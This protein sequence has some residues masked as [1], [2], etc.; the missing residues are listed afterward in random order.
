[1]GHRYDTNCSF[2]SKHFWNNSLT[3]VWSLLWST[4]NVF[5]NMIH[6]CNFK[7]RLIQMNLFIYSD[8]CK[9]VKWKCECYSQPC[10]WVFVFSSPCIVFTPLK[11]C[12]KRE[13]QHVVFFCFFNTILT[14]E[15][16]LRGRG[17]LVLLLWYP[18]TSFFNWKCRSCAVGKRGWRNMEGSKDKQSSAVRLVTYVNSC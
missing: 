7:H 12:W 10:N 16:K 9:Y 17:V 13:A 18:V 8:M 3:V 14:R 15:Y 11:A 2:D 4:P 6:S 5:A 1:M